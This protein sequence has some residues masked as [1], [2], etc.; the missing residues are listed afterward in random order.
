MEAII[1]GILEVIFREAPTAIPAIRDLL[2]KKNPT[3][4]DFDKAIAQIK[5]DTYGKLVPHSQL[6]PTVPPVTPA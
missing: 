3:K 5:A 2:A 4:D 1:I 6:P